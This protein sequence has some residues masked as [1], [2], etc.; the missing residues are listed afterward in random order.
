M[1]KPN[2]WGWDDWQ[3]PT[4]INGVHITK[5]ADCGTELKLLKDSTEGQKA[6]CGDC[7]SKRG[8]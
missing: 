1:S 6:F 5:C 8:K 4:T 3:E 2:G 7:W